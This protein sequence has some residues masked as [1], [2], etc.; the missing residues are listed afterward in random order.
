MNLRK[1]TPLILGFGLA[2][3]LLLHPGLAYAEHEF[4]E[5]TALADKYETD[6]GT[7]GHKYTEVYEYFFYPIK[8]TVRKIFEIGI[9]KGASLKM[10]RDYFP[11]A[12]IY[13]IDIDDKSGLASDV[14]KTFVADQSDREQLQAFINTYEGDFDLILDDGGHTMKQQQVSL[15]YLFKY[16]KPGGYYIVEDV[17]TS[18]Y[19]V[20]G[21][22]AGAEPDEA[23]TTMTMINHFIRT[24]QINSSYM[25]NEEMQ[26]LTDHIVYC[27]LFS[28]NSGRSITWIIKKK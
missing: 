1:Y 7:K 23:N 6:K 21:G 26:Y 19:D 14:L 22:N 3:A 13:G 4:G 28:R 16:V 2:I 12:V 17:H 24:G 10:F 27:N 25:T 5:L 18:L 15:G 8:D 9:A 11:Q 20:F